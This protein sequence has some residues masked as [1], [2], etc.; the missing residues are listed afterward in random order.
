MIVEMKKIT[1]I[2]LKSDLKGVIDA[3]K[4]TSA[5]ERSDFKKHSKE[6]NADTT[7]RDNLSALLAR[8][9][10]AIEF[11]RKC[12]ADFVYAYKRHVKSH[13]GNAEDFKAEYDLKRVKAKPPEFDEVRYSELLDTAG[14]ENEVL[15]I[16]ESL[17]NASEKLH[18][19]KT[20]LAK[21]KAH[22]AEL[23]PYLN[24]NVNF[25]LLHNTDKTFILAGIIPR[26]LLEK[27]KSDLKFKSDIN[28]DAVIIEEFDA[29]DNKAA[30]VCIGNEDDYYLVNSIF[31]YKFE[32]CKFN[33]AATAKEKTAE[34]E[35]EN[36]KLY[37]G[38]IKLLYDTCLS[39]ESLKLLKLYHDYLNNELETEEVMHSTLKTKDSY[40]L[41][42][43]I[44]GREE[45]KITQIVNGVSQEVLIKTEKPSDGDTPPTLV[46]NKSLIAPYQSITN[47]Y[48]PPSSKDLD[49]NIFVAF[50]YF[51]FFGLMIGDIGYG[52]VMSAAALVY[53]KLFKPKKGMKDLVLIICMGGVSAVLWGAFFGSL[54]GFSKTGA[55]GSTIPLL[56]CVFDPIND[57][58]IFLIFSLALGVVQ[59]VFGLTLKFY[60][61]ARRGKIADA[62]CDAGF[63]IALFAG[64]ILFVIGP[65]L[66]FVFGLTLEGAQI[67]SSIG[68]WT[69][70]A[71]AALIFLTAGRKGK[72]IG[73][74]LSGG[75]GGIYS[76]V[77]YFSDVLSYARL[78]GLGLVGAV[79]AMIANIMAGMLFGIPVVGIPLGIL[80]ALVFHVFNLALGLLSAYVHNA[81]LQFVEFFGKFY[82]GGGRPFT[83]L[84][85]GTKYVRIK[86]SLLDF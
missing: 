42:G 38:N 63:R 5:F 34:L 33:H 79:I 21:N 51:I 12:R 15:N 29:P 84:G 23:K 53:L 31:D 60:N 2:G 32:R 43:W 4:G 71:S 46:I 67:L 14:R 73:G 62:V 49:P 10:A 76:L 50:F 55:D 26:I 56:P 25:N 18:D 74:K 27:F 68:I 22:I 81:R 65:L 11:D 20:S 77:G 80:I 35:E 17:E 83:P 30:V 72:G 48:S 66:K 59:L 85:G 45:Q 82:E 36:A 28:S 58:L 7:A 19:I 40:I 9:K 1:L 24:L 37:G 3:L 61:L 78:F 54:F 47:M 86:S 13:S 39:S 70:A 8:A 6:Q 16:I 57:S 44:V 69:A 64:I 52:I 75:F 41:N